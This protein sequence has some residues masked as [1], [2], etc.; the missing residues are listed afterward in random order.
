MVEYGLRLDGD[1]LRF[2][3]NRKQLPPKHFRQIA[4]KI[5]ALLLDPFPPDCKPVLDAWR[6]DTGEYRI[7]YD[8]FTPEKTVVV[9]LVGKRNDDE[10]YKRFARKMGKR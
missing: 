6:V 10:V 1:V 9:L 5:F 2:L 7:L 8:V 4:L 3:S